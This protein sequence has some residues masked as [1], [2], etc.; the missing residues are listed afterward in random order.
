MLKTYIKKNNNRHYIVKT[1]KNII[2]KFTKK[3]DFSEITWP[4]LYY[5]IIYN[6]KHNTITQRLLST[7]YCTHTHTH[8][9]KILYTHN[10]RCIII[11][12]I[13]RLTRLHTRHII[14]LYYTMIPLTDDVCPYIL[15]RFSEEHFYDDVISLHVVRTQHNRNA[16]LA[17][18]TRTHPPLIS[19]LCLLFETRIE[20]TVKSGANFSQV[21]KIQYNIIYGLGAQCP[22]TQ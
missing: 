10:T 7:K 3:Y 21:R 6:S 22:G 11:Y 1:I 8:T 12:V 19:R 16:C 15:Y 13:L 5:F 2:R 14:R 9:F 20:L 18:K 4:Y 17:K